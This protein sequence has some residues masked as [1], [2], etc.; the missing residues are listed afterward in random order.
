MK[1]I[2]EIE[3]WGVNIPFIFLAMIYWAL[4]SL[5]LPLNLPFHPYFM[6][7][8]AYALYFG[9]IQRLFFPAKNYL[10]LHIASLILLAIPI[11]YF[12]I[13]AS[14][15]LT[16]TEVW[17]LKD[18][19]MYGYNT[20]KLPINALVL[21]SPFSS[22]IAWVFYP[23]YWLLITPLLLYILGVNV[24]VFSVNLR[25]KPVFGLH[26]L[27]IFL[28]IILS[29]FF[30][31]LFPFIGVVY[32]LTIYRKTFTF[33]SITGISSLLSLIVIPL[34]SLYFGD[35]VHAFTLGIMSNLFFSC[36]TYSTSRYNYNKV[37][38]SILLSD[39]AY[40]LRFFYFEI[41]GI[42]WIVAVIYFLY[43]IKDNFYLTS[44]KLGLSMRFIRMQ[45]E[46]RGSP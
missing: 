35:F 34:L 16:I 43:L 40:I 22:I 41:S 19:K 9:M 13:I 31:I 5:S 1:E 29:Y 23:N 28:I 6:L 36:I 37:V 46:N 45:K 24:G 7:L 32:F 25:T 26:Q 27:P 18:L 33:K 10:A 11:Q 17:A 8:G 4:G 21:S 2:K 15:V 44:I 39:L 12:Q 38:I 14:V 42:F 20:K 3:P 30:P